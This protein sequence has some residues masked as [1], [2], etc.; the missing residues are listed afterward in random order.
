MQQLL[1]MIHS[2]HPV[3]KPLRTPQPSQTTPLLQ[4]IMQL[5]SSWRT[6]NE[7]SMTVTGVM[8]LDDLRW[9]PSRPW[10]ACTK[11]RNCNHKLKRV[12]PPPKTMER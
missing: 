4:T 8:Q 2:K 6:M 11:D 7:S 10:I 12:L 3:Q 9:R 1:L 5:G